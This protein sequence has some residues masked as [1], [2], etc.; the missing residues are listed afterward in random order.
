M[1]YCK[2]QLTFR[3]LLATLM[4]LP[5]ALGGSPFMHSRQSPLTRT[6]SSNV[7]T[8][9]PVLANPYLA[10]GGTEALGSKQV[11]DFSNSQGKNVFDAIYQWKVIDFLYPN[12]K[13]RNDA[14]RTKQFI[15]ENNLPLGVDRYRDRIFIT[16]PRW[17]PGVPATLSYL[18]LPVQDPSLPLIPYPDWSFHTSPQNPDCSRLVS[19]YRIYVDECERLWVLDAGVIDTLTNLQQICPPKILAFNLQTDELLF[20][21]TLPA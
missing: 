9:S 12:L 13:A 8:Q 3:L 1:N 4:V 15:P 19:V 6:V 18:P 21:Y 11:T 20:S 7:T 2:L 17:N 16:T 14:I 10:P 5:A